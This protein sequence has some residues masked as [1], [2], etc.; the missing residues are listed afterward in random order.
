MIRLNTVILIS[1]AAMLLL[2]LSDTESSYLHLIKNIFAISGII[3]FMFYEKCNLYKD[4]LN[5]NYKKIYLSTDKILTPILKTI[6]K[7]I[8]PLNIGANIV[9]SLGSF[10]VV[11]F[12]LICLIV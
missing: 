8:P 6:N 7:I 4:R 1:I 3:L 11:L 9:I 2:L 10:I 12:L 5:P